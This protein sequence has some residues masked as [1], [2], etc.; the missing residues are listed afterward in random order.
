MIVLQSQT[1]FHL[2]KGS[3]REIYD[4][5]KNYRVI[6]IEDYIN[7]GCRFILLLSDSFFFFKINGMVNIMYR[8]TISDVTIRYFCHYM[9][10]NHI[11]ACLNF[12]PQKEKFMKLPNFIK[13]MILYL[14]SGPGIL[15][16]CKYPMF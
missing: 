8:Y 12:H 13:L 10:N 1:A 6:C 14:R 9:Q 3:N 11:S 5:Q 2:S 7:S 16:K 15:Q 4:K